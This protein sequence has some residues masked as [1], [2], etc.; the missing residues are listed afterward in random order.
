MTSTSSTSRRTSSRAHRRGDSRRHACDAFEVVHE[1]PLAEMERRAAVVEPRR[2]AFKTALE[3][4]GSHQRDRR[5]QTSIAIARRAGSRTTTRRRSRASYERAGAAAISVLTEP[6]FFDGSLDHLVAVR[7]RNVAPDS[8]EGFHHR[9]VSDSRGAGRGR[10][11]DSAD[12]CRVETRRFCR[13]FMT[14]PRTPVWMCS[15]RC[16]TWSRSRSRLKPAHRLS[17]STIEIFEHWP[18][19]P[20]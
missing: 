16:T 10:R 17:E 7:T 2:G 19:T 15:S 14:S 9:S 12:C 8:A 11:C 4:P 5:M 13:I 3:R 18:S 6:A 1:C 20:R